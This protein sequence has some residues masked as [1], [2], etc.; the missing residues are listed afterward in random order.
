MSLFLVFPPCFRFM[1]LFHFFF[2]SLIRNVNFSF[3]V[4][5]ITGPDS[6][7]LNY[8]VKVDER[9]EWSS[10]PRNST[11]KKMEDTLG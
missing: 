4:Y 1:P 2:V 11:E 8:I 3:P 10:L 7:L 5:V 9:R 6:S